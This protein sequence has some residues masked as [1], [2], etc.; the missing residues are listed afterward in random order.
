VLEAQIAW[1]AHVEDGDSH[2]FV[3]DGG[4]RGTESLHAVHLGVEPGGAV[5]LLEYEV[6]A[7]QAPRG[8]AYDD[9]SALPVPDGVPGIVPA[10]IAAALDVDLADDR[11]G[12]TRGRRE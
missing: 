3:D 2:D 5:G 9:Q 1:A 10:T 7:E 8:V 12:T 6:N 4:R 11:Q